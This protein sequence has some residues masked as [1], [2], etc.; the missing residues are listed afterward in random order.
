MRMRV[1]GMDYEQ[2]KNLD[3]YVSNGVRVRPGGS[4]AGSVVC[5]RREWNCSCIHLVTME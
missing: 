2:H 3:E 5:R 1:E 4:M